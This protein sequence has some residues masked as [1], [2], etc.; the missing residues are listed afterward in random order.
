[1][2]DSVGEAH[3]RP[4]RARCTLHVLHV[5]PTDLA[6]GAQVYVRALADHANH[7]AGQR[8]EVVVLFAGERVAAHADHELAVPPGRLGSAG[9]DPRAVRRLRR[10]VRDRRPDAVVAHGADALKYAVFLRSPDRMVVCHAI[11]VAAPKAR[12]GPH[13]LLHRWLLSR[14]DLVTAVSQAVADE[15]RSLFRVPAER[16]RVVPNGRDAAVFTPGGAR[17]AGA[18]PRLLFVGHLTATKRPD[19]FLAVVARLR[20]R[21]CAFEARIVGD[22]PLA[23]EVSRIA[24]PLDV[25]VLGRRVDVASV[26]R[27]GDVLLFTSRPEGE[28]MPGVFIEASLA[29]VPVVATDVPGAHDVIEDGRTGRVLP[30]DDVSG[31]TEAVAELLEDA[32]LRA[33]MG[34]AARARCEQLFSMEHSASVFLGELAAL[35]RRRGAPSVLRGPRRQCGQ[36]GASHQ[37]DDESRGQTR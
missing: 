5:L 2:P 4:F 16:V 28:G 13:R 36:H 1:M 20:T 32:G 3:R 29:G 11:G 23:D 24:A 25:Q 35:E 22:G 34:R 33:A 9:L 17:D 15:L 10:L 12:S 6:R 31:L 30:R 8:H 19:L 14:A 26:L 7:V 27:S 37:D 21:G 18:P